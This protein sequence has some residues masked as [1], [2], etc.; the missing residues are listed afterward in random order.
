MARNGKWGEGGAKVSRRGAG[1]PRAEA[2]SKEA[3]S[4]KILSINDAQKFGVKAMSA[5]ASAWKKPY[6]APEI[7]REN[8]HFELV[9]FNAA[10]NIIQNDNAF[11]AYRA[12]DENGMR[13]AV[14]NLAEDEAFQ[15]ALLA[16]ICEYK[17]TDTPPVVR[18]NDG[19]NEN[20]VPPRR[21]LTLGQR[22]YWGIYRDNKLMRRVLAAALAE[23]N[24]K[25]AAEVGLGPDRPSTPPPASTA[26]VRDFQPWVDAGR[27]QTQNL[28][29]E[30]L[31]SGKAAKKDNGAFKLK[32]EDFVHDST[33]AYL[34]TATPEEIY[35]IELGL[36]AYESA[37]AVLMGRG[38]S[39][40]EVKR[41]IAPIDAGL[42]YHLWDQIS[43]TR[44]LGGAT[45]YPYYK[46]GNDIVL[47]DAAFELRNGITRNAVISALAELKNRISPEQLIAYQ[48]YKFY[49]EA[50]A[51]AQEDRSFQVQ[52]P[53]NKDKT[54]D[55]PYAE[56]LAALNTA[57][58][59]RYT[60]QTNI[61]NSVAGRITGDTYKTY[62]QNDFY[63]DARKK[64][65]PLPEE[66]HWFWKQRKINKH[67]ESVA[68]G[69][70]RQE[71][72]LENESPAFANPVEALKIILPQFQSAA[73]Q[74]K[75][76][77][78]AP[79]S[80]A[81]RNQIAQQIGISDA[82]LAEIIKA[83][84]RANPAIVPN[85]APPSP[86][87]DIKAAV[88]RSLLAQINPAWENPEVELINIYDGRINGL[89]NEPRGTRVPFV[90]DELNILH[91]ST[92][93]SKEDRD[94]RLVA[95]LK[96]LFPNPSEL[97]A[98]AAQ[99]AVNT[100]EQIRAFVNSGILDDKQ[101]NGVPAIR[102]RA[103]ATDS[104]VSEDLAEVIEIVKEQAGQVAAL[105][106]ALNKQVA[107]TEKALD[108]GARKVEQIERLLEEV[109]QLKD[110]LLSNGRSQPLLNLGE[111]PEGEDRRGTPAQAARGTTALHVC[112][113]AAASGEPGETSFGPRQGLTQRIGA[114]GEPSAS[115]APFLRAVK[116]LKFD[117][118]RFLVQQFGQEGL[119][120]IH[121]HSGEEGEDLRH[122]F[123]Y[124][125]PTKQMTLRPDSTLEERKALALLYAEKHQQEMSGVIEIDAW[126]DPD[127]VEILFNATR[128]AEAGC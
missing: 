87:R 13:R 20:T 39:E 43:R 29:W 108:L 12:V 19:L 114:V 92:P 72:E 109:R 7:N 49:K 75:A 96:R 94:A 22:V 81:D 53:K 59:K 36:E 66:N 9:L 64:A 8:G 99:N 90:Q 128:A 77:R 44:E 48:A 40:S 93:S 111:E 6:V 85:G 57:P 51:G 71:A 23:V 34:I 58:D 10:V 115:D 11:A 97:V 27:G 50:V 82:A 121:Y 112:A 31:Y 100:R 52:A 46:N 47:T 89:Y 26:K 18:E 60:R 37:D 33:L 65:P 2:Q 76:I 106:E 79:K 45:F 15:A 120:Y 117:G 63:T 28:T 74:P 98:Q 83:S 78:V 110:A 95:E 105:L 17:G 38:V 118:G 68:S 73:G 125:E 21:G 3:V 70:A 102:K 54:I 35:N 41:Q 86:V 116:A 56:F 123:S 119:H 88:S 61:I 30:A 69:M 124:H 16:R 25:P 122:G 104:A 24:K 107:V 4:G 101:E 62:F 42:E 14:N 127:V 113:Q 91:A 84:R 103:A 32:K 55:I 5:V 1:K 126:A 80:F 67:N